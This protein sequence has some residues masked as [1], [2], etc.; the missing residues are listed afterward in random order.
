MSSNG[1]ISWTDKATDLRFGLSPD[2]DVVHQPMASAYNPPRPFE[3]KSIN[4]DG[5]NAHTTE[6]NKIGSINVGVQK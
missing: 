6:K 1:Y 2:L 3:D 5:L 4:E